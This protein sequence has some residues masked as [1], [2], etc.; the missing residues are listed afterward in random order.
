MSMSLPPEPPHGPAYVPLI[1][2]FLSVIVRS[3]IEKMHCQAPYPKPND[4]NTMSKL[5]LTA[6]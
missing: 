3:L 6:F 4:H 5:I 1:D 2:S